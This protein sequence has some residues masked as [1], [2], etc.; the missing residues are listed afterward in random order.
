MHQSLADFLAEL[1]PDVLSDLYQNVPVGLHSLDADGVFLFINDTELEWLGYERNELLGKLQF[2][3]LLPPEQLTLFQ[4]RFF[5]LKETGRITNIR[6]TLLRKDGSPLPVQIDS[7]ALYDEDGQYL[8]SRSVVIDL[9]VQQELEEQIQQ[10]NDELKRLNE[11]LIVLNQTKNTFISAV[12]HDLQNPV[13]NLR[14]LAAKFRK[15]ADTLTLQQ[16]NW[17][18]DL[19]NTAQ[20]IGNLISQTLDANRIEHDANAPQLKPV[21][22]QSLLQSLLKHFS[23]LADRKSIQLISVPDSLVPAIA[24]DATYV[25]EILE[26]LLSNAIKFSPPGSRVIL[27]THIHPDCIGI[28]VSDEGPGIPLSE[29]SRLFGRYVTLSTHPTAGESSTGLGLFIA[30]EYAERI[31]GTLYYE[32]HP[33]T[34][35][36]FVLKLPRA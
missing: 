3:D 29:R 28:S 24:T 17:I 23:N 4:T 35:A 1:D 18:E 34:G 6:Y 33:Q 26:N 13:T 12:A 21:D 9:T 11:Q 22:F 19:D 8:M 32:E 20:R 31:G 30:K 2:A 15:T 27:T 10:K 7:S 5:T 36:T 16:K 25:I 14:M